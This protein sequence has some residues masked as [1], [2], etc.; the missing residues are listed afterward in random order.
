[1]SGILRERM[2]ER[3]WNL[4]GVRRRFAKDYSGGYRGPLGRYTIAG[5]IPRQ[6]ALDDEGSRASDRRGN[7]P[8]LYEL[9]RT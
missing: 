5:A 3:V 7:C 2:S 8:A 1:L 9:K 4:Y 6:V